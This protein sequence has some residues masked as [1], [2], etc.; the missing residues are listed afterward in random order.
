MLAGVKPQNGVQE[1]PP[2]NPTADPMT[3]TASKMRLTQLQTPLIGL[4][5]ERSS[6]PTLTLTP[7]LSLTPITL[8]LPGQ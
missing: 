2:T 6:E 5:D 3:V 7:P 1:P 8:L 4:L